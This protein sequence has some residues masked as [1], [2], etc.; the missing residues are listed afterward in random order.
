MGLPAEE[1]REQDEDEYL[2]RRS[3]FRNVHFFFYFNIF[4]EQFQMYSR[5]RNLTLNSR[6]AHTWASISTSMPP[7]L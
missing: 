5:L 2:M 7:I 6:V 3:D 1:G 4:Y